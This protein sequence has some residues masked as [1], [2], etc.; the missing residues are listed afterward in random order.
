MAVVLHHFSLFPLQKM[1]NN[2]IMLYKQN[3]HKFAEEL[4]ANNNILQLRKIAEELT[5]V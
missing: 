4:S 3:S 2:D 1:S 5:Y